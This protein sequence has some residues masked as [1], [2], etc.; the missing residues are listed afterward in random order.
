[1]RSVGIVWGFLIFNIEGWEEMR[2]GY[3]KEIV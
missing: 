3:R 1:M 2:S